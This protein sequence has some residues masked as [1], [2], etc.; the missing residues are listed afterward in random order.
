MAYVTLQRALK[1]GDRSTRIGAAATLLQ[2]A[3]RIGQGDYHIWPLENLGW[4]PQLPGNCRLG[5]V[6]AA[7][8]WMICDLERST[9]QLP[10][11]AVVLYRALDDASANVVDVAA[12]CLRPLLGR[13]RPEGL[14]G[15]R[16]RE[17]GDV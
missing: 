8:R 17:A 9:D 11:A 12:A 13:L 3:D 2:Q 1:A 4:D 10:G 6:L 5:L 16:R 7:V 14:D 15:L